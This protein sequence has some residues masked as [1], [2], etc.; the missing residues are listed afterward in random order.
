MDDFAAHATNSGSEIMQDTVNSIEK[1]DEGFKVTT[2]NK[3][4]SSKFVI[5]ASGNT[6]RKL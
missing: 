5:L 1:T 6:Y 3:E 4:F 2:T